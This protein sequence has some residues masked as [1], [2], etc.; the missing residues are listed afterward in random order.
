MIKCVIFALPL[1]WLFSYSAWSD[2]TNRGADIVAGRQLALK[3]C[4]SCHVVTADQR[5]APVMT[6]PT[7]SFEEIAQQPKTDAF[8]LQGFLSSTQS[9]VSHPAAMP[10]PQ[11]TANQIRDLVAY[12]LSLRE[13]S[14]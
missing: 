14:K 2:T 3:F 11:L 8:F 13:K 10:N 9:N 6:P 7:R 1:L 12:I 4:A 5:E